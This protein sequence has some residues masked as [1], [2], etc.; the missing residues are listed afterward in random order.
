MSKH[1][2]DFDKLKRLLAL[3]N[4]EQPPPGYFDRL[5]DQVLQRIEAQRLN[6][7]TKGSVFQRF[8]AEFDLRPLL[9]FSYVVVIGGVVAC[10][11]LFRGENPSSIQFSGGSEG[12]P[13]VN[14]L[15]FPEISAPAESGVAA[16]APGNGIQGLIP[17][18]NA[19]SDFLFNAN[20]V[21]GGSTQPAS[22]GAE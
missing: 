15:I 16:F 14:S 10:Y 19:V 4:G 22:F 1:Q 9:A 21:L 6:G 8:L 7:A 3:K 13:L 5:P 2:D 11:Q 20:G 18:T 17:A 12:Q